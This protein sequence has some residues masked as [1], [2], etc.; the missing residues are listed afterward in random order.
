[1]FGIFVLEDRD[2]RIQLTVQIEVDPLHHEKGDVFVRYAIHDRMLEHMRERSM[3][4]IVQQDGDHSA[5][6]FLLGD[7]HTLEPQ[8]GNGLVHQ[9]HR[10]ERVTETAVH[11]TGVNEVR[12]PQ[13]TD[14]VQ[15]LHVGVLQHVKYQVI[16]DRKEPKDGVVYDLTFVSHNKKVRKVTK[17]IPYTQMRV[18]ENQF[19]LRFYLRMSKICSN[20]AADFDENH[21]PRCWNR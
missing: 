5:R 15:T 14:A 20:F 18:R 19:F 11:R 9:V 1:M 2:R 10:T 6:L 4:D 7:L 8:R 21:L 13:L 3:T 16:R 12:Q 17:N